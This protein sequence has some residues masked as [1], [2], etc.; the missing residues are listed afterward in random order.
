MLRAVE[1]RSAGTRHLGLATYGT[2]LGH[3]LLRSIDR[4]QRIYR[5]MVSRGFDGAVRAGLSVRAGAMELPGWI[6]GAYLGGWCLFFLLA[7]YWNFAEA[8]G[9]HL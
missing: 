7:R 9:N 1:V 6:N 8:I 4:A 3:L 5:A 2:L